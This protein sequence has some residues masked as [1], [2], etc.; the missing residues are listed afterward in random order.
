MERTQS[1][2]DYERLK[3][4]N[5]ALRLAISERTGTMPEH[6]DALELGCTMLIDYDRAAEIFAN[7]CQ[8]P[9][10]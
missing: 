10:K 2:I 6:I 8:D 4:F 7:C 3:Y 5:L 1:N 9:E